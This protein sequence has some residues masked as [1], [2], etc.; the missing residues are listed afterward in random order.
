MT[1]RFLCLTLAAVGCVAL[2]RQG[3][4]AP[5][6]DNPLGPTGEYNGSIT[7]GGSYD[8]YTGNAKRFIDDLTVTGSLG[9]YPLKW[10][11]V[12]NTRNPSA[13]SHSY[14]WGLWVKPYEYYHYYPN[15]YEGP[16]AQVT[17][18]DGRI[19]SFAIPEQPYIYEA[20]SN[21]GVP[22]DRLV[23]MGNGNFDLLMR[24]GGKVRFEQPLQIGTSSI[25]IATQI[26]DPYGQVTTLTYD[27]NRVLSRITEPGGRY[28]QISYTNGHYT[29]VQAFSAPGQLTET[30]TYTYDGNDLTGANYDD[31]THATYIYGAPNIGTLGGHLIQSCEDV[32]FAGPMKKIVYEYVT[33]PHYNPA[34]G[35][36][37]REKN[38]LGQTVTEVVYPLSQSTTNEVDY[39]RTEIRG[40]FVQD[41]SNNWVHPTRLF[42]YSIGGG[43]LVS[44]TDFKGRTTQT[45]FVG[46]NSVSVYRKTVTDA[47]SNTTLTDLSVNTDAVMKI[48]HPPT[49]A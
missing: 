17:Y 41:A 16:G 28:L 19:L 4:A 14:E 31:G 49:Y 38:L 39:Q 48:T 11:R 33:D 3:L 30:V 10:T 23:H 21:G 9:A 35:Q 15:L 43:E 44:F 29:T 24:D 26:I 5:G 13:W 18:P 25:L 6:I 42:Q 36:I 32:R 27:A 40:D 20:D 8:P 45:S 2:A 22:Q 47:R 12:L 37:K 46:L 7:T 1:P 34:W